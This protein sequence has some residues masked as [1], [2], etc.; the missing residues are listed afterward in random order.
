MTTADSASQAPPFEVPKQWQTAMSMVSINAGLFPQ[1]VLQH[2]YKLYPLQAAAHPGYTELDVWRSQRA[3]ERGI[4]AIHVRHANA[5]PTNIH[6]MLIYLDELDAIT[7]QP[8]LR[9]ITNTSIRHVLGEPCSNCP[10]WLP[11]R[12][13]NYDSTAHGGSSSESHHPLIASP[14]N[15]DP[16]TD[17]TTATT[18]YQIIPCCEDWVKC[19]DFGAPL[20]SEEKKVPEMIDRLLDEM[21]H[22]TALL[23]ARDEEIVKLLAKQADPGYRFQ[24]VEEINNNNN[25]EGVA[26]AVAAVQQVHAAF[27]TEAMMQHWWAAAAVVGFLV[28]LLFR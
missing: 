26:A 1:Q 22:K 12:S 15:M 8:I 6:L 2:Y 27:D 16:T 20:S 3:K 7:K 19:A 5:D 24:S 17:P 18:P 25:N 21:R 28:V 9:L 10:L 13:I 11:V 14:S 4:K 23:V